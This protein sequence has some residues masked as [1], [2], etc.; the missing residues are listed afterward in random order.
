MAAYDRKRYG[1]TPPDDRQLYEGLQNGCCPLVSTGDNPAP[2][3]A[4]G[5]EPGS[6]LTGADRHAG[7]C[8]MAHK[9][10]QGF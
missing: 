4:H 9:L 2:N 5:D 8:M 1:F 3:P 6:A 10:P 7:T